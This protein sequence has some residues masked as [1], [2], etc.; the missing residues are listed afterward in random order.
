MGDVIFILD[1]QDASTRYTMGGK[2]YGKW[3]MDM[4]M[5]FCRILADFRA[6]FECC[7]WCP[8][9]EVEVPEASVIGTCGCAA[10][11]ARRGQR[12]LGCL[13]VSQSWPQFESRSQPDSQPAA[14]A[15]SS[16]QPAADPTPHP[17][18][19]LLAPES[20]QNIRKERK[21]KTHAPPF[22]LF[23]Q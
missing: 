14:R 4:Q 6:G 16:Q 8:R 2:S 18:F 21:N 13:A 10:A 23:C 12:S 15:A 7:P 9:P 11:A 19:T 3:Q 20:K 17:L 1:V 22:I 5:D